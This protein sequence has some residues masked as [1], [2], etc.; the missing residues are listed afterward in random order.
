[1]KILALSFLALISS[2]TAQAA[3]NATCV[4][5]SEMQEIAKSFPQFQDLAGKDYCYDGG[6]DSH[7]IAGI[8]FMRKTQFR[9]SM[10]RSSD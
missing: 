10:D 7:L 9:S 8:E 5:Q 1:M 4:A 3:K 6:A 2:F